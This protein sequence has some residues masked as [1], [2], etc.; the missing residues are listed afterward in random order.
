M[1]AKEHRMTLLSPH[2]LADC[3]LKAGFD[4]SPARKTFGAGPDTAAVVMLATCLGESAARTFRGAGTEIMGR[5]NTG[6]H[7][8]NWDHG[9]G[10]LSGV[11]QAHRI[12]ARGG[13]WRDPYVNLEICFEIFEDAGGTFKPWH[14]FT[15]G[16]YVETL[17]DARIAIAAPWP[18]PSIEWIKR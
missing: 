17:P 16:A 11:F 12:R 6:A 7:I 18:C 1:S 2:E 5:S 13:N 10:Q 4:N 8:G 15:G 14:I 9:V 3:V